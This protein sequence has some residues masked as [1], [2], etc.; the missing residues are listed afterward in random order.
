LFTC[1]YVSL[2]RH[3]EWQIELLFKRWKSYCRIDEF[4]GRNDVIKM[5]RFWARLCGVLIQHWLSIVAAWSPTLRVSLAKTAKLTRDFAKDIA[6]A[7]SDG[8]HLMTVRERFRRMAHAGCKR[9]K[10]KKN[11]GTL[12]LLRDPDLLEYVLT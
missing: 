5:T 12:E 9:T 1:Y 2:G 11:P 4:D 3:Y 7:L 8:G 6:I 10:R